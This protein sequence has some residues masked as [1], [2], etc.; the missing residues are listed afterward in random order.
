MQNLGVKSYNPTV[1][2]RLGR[3]TLVRYRNNTAYLQCLKLCDTQVRPKYR[4]LAGCRYVIQVNAPLSSWKRLDQRFA[5]TDS[6]RRH[7]GL[8]TFRGVRPSAFCRAGNTVG[9]YAE[10]ARAN[11]LAGNCCRLGS[12]GVWFITEVHT[13][14]GNCWLHLRR[15]I[16]GI[17][18]Q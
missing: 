7:V 11:T 6:P 9:L 12:A 8:H 10:S 3:S 17:Y 18:L 2:P 1:R 16:V 4:G 15:R 13:F 14:W 5:N